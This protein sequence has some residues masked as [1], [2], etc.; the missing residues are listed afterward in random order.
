[1]DTRY[2]YKNDIKQ[3]KVLLDLQRTSNNKDSAKDFNAKHSYL[4]K[5]TN[6]P[7]A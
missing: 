7:V 3:L 5:V 6:N 4:G 2:W 1:M